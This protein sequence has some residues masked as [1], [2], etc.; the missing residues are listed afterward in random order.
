MKT[1]KYLLVSAMPT[2]NGG[3][4]LGHLAAQFL[5]QDIF[6]RYHKRKGKIVEFYGGFDVYD[7]AISVAARKK[8]VSTYEMAI[9]YQDIIKKELKYFNI[10]ID[11][12]LNYLEPELIEKSKSLINTLNNIFSQ[13]IVTKK[14]SYPYSL[15]NIPVTGN[16]LFGKCK[17]CHSDIKGYS[18][19]HCGISIT[20][21]DIYDFDFEKSYK[22]QEIIWKDKKVSFLSTPVV[23]LKNYISSQPISDD[24]KILC[25]KLNQ[26]K[27]I[28]YQWTAIDQWGMYINPNDKDE[29]FFNRNFTLIEQ[30]IVADIFY[31]IHGENP[32]SSDSKVK[33]ILAYG[34]DNVGL[35]LVDLPSILLGNNIFEPY[36]Q[37]WVSHF[38]CINGKKMSTS[39]NFAIWLNDII[40]SKVS[41]DS[42]RAYICSV[43]SRDKDIDLDL[44]ALLEHDRFSSDL[45]QGILSMNK[46]SQKDS[47]ENTLSHTMESIAKKIDDIFSSS[48]L[49]FKEYYDRY[50]EFCALI[51]YVN[52]QKS[53]TLWVEIFD[54]YFSAL[55]PNIA[56]FAKKNVRV[57]AKK[58][59]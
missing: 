26:R 15:D 52:C 58:S 54:N 56:L 29:V 9:H 10:D 27:I 34:K 31:K 1:Q 35:L 49:N 40:A 43:Y 37:H 17:K 12:F 41:S 2:P 44:K 14:I 46:I 53:A 32:F 6:K 25:H 28:N 24:I 39:K 20:P 13:A 50:K 42:T 59:K 33:T 7:N 48:D 8:N 16:W 18:C 38:Y 4:H 47:G 55:V 22:S 51:Y 5:P 23:D 3:L 30:M 36:K 19:D 45:K 57:Y 21:N 11:R